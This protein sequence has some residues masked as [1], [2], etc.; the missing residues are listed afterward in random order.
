MKK[1]IKKLFFQGVSLK[2]QEKLIKLLFE[3]TINKINNFK[4]KEEI[5]KFLVNEL[6]NK[7]NKNDNLKSLLLTLQ[8]ITIETENKLRYLESKTT[9]IPEISNYN[10]T[11]Q[12]KTS[13]RINNP[14]WD[15]LEIKQYSIPGMISDEE[16]Q[17]YKYIGQFYSGKGEI[18][19]LGPWLGLSTHYIIDGLI[20]NPYFKSK[21]IYVY[22]DF[23][24][25][26][27]WMDKHTPEEERLENYQDF[28]PLFNRYTS[29][30]NEYV[31]VYKCKI[32]DYRGNKHLPQLEWNK[33]LVELMYIDCGRTFDANQGWYQ[34]F[35]PYFIPNVTL[36]IMQ[37][38]GLHK[39]LPPLWYNQTKQFTESKGNQLQII[40]EL[41]KGNIATFLYKGGMDLGDLKN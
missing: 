23:I 39:Q 30:L 20:D 29:G 26:S 11:S 1:I 33:G 28:Q 37:D 7:T 5:I 41:T 27:A 16:K 35:S 18:I 14:V 9:E 22:D 24:W 13:V 40:H 3:N 19:E 10:N 31:Q 15:S 36:L 38:W 2:N 32:T 4:E 6:V 8:K 12:I 17:Y 21:K 34:I 25:R